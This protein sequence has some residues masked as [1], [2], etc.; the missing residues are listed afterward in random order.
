[1]SGGQAKANRGPVVL[2]IDGVFSNPLLVEEVVNNI[3]K[4]VERIG[5]LFGSRGVTVAVA[6]IV[7][8]YHAV[9]VAQA[10]NQFTKHVRR[11]GKAVKKH[12]GRCVFWASFAVE[13]PQSIDLR[14]VVSH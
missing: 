3:G 1:M 14:G 7:R 12:D 13:D 10:R 4:V 5:E 8:C 9:L 2:N 6:G 11:T